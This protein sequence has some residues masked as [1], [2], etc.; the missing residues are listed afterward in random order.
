MPRMTTTTISSVRVKAPSRA[1]R[2]GGTATGRNVIAEPTIGCLEDHREIP[3]RTEDAFD[4]DW[5]SQ[6]FA[7][8]PA[9]GGRETS[10]GFLVQTASA[11]E[12]AAALAV[13]VRDLPARRPHASRPSPPR[14]H[15]G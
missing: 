6:L 3:R 11:G 10:P 15:E 8:L 2:E 12:G 13:A 7:E 4:N 9:C 1:A 5:T 14:W